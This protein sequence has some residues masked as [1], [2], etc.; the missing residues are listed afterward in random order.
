[1]CNKKRG[2]LYVTTH[3]SYV[4]TIAIRTFRSYHWPAYQLL[5]GMQF[6]PKARGQYDER[7]GFYVRDWTSSRYW[8]DSSSMLKMIEGSHLKWLT[9]VDRWRYRP[10]W[11]MTE[12]RS[13]LAPVSHPMPIL[14]TC[15][16]DDRQ[17]RYHSNETTTSFCILTTYTLCNIFPTLRTRVLMLMLYIA[18]FDTKQLTKVTL[19]A[20][21]LTSV[22]HTLHLH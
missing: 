3:T 11:W 13:L 5:A 10:W 1:M 4:R 12:T 21:T 15:G 9:C 8:L 2:S 18:K 19:Q 22:T 7:C 14:R 20:R 17:L 16:A 6:R